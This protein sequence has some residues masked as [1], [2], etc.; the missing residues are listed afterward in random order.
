MASD[1]VPGCRHAGLLGYGSPATILRRDDRDYG[2]KEHQGDEID[3]E[4]ELNRNP[5]EVFPGGV[6]PSLESFYRP[7]IHILDSMFLLTA[8]TTSA[9]E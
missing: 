5:R 6:S 4:G 3:E 9:E 7:R 1:I 8:S 2:D